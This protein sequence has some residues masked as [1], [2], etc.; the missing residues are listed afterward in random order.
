MVDE[1]KAGPRILVLG[2]GALGALYGFLLARGGAQVY[3]VARS[4][5]VSLRE[6]GID[7]CSEKYGNHQGF[8]PA[9]V[10]RSAEQVREEATQRPFDYILCTIKICPEQ[11]LTGK[12]IREYLPSG[13]GRKRE[14]LT[15]IVFVEV[16]HMI[17]L[18]WRLLD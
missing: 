8:K 5:A 4:N 9:G 17:A 13:K 16:G 15:T 3:A 6:R 12:W 7:I 18:S 1:N 11:R 10:F 2:F 14:D